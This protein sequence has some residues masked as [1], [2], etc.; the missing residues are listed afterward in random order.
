MT[1]VLTKPEDRLAT[2]PTARALIVRE[3]LQ[4][5]AEQRKLLLEYVKSQ[6][7]EDLDY[8]KIPGTD[9]PTLLKPGAEKLT[10]LFRT[11]ARFQIEKEI[12]DWD[13]GLF[14]YRF[15]CV[16]EDAEGNIVSEGI[17]SAN[18]REKRY[19]W[20]KAERTCPTCG[21]AAI[22]RS[23]FP[24][25]EEPEAQPG[26]Y[27]YGKIG[28][29]GANFPADDEEITNQVEGQIENPDIADCVN[30]LQKIS[31]KRALVDAV[32]G[33]SLC[34]DLF[35]QDLEDLA[36]TAATPATQPSA[37]AAKNGE[38]KNETKS[39]K[40]D[41]L[42]KLE[43]MIDDAKSR[44]EFKAA[45]FVVNQ[46][47]KSAGLTK[48]QR[49]GLAA[50][51]IAK[52]ATFDAT[53]PSELDAARAD[54]VAAI[55]ARAQTYA[56]MIFQFGKRVCAFDPDRDPIAPTLEDLKADELKS[57]TALIEANIVIPT[58]PFDEKGDAYEPDPIGDEGE[59]LALAN[60]KGKRWE[61]CLIWLNTT[62]RTNYQ[63]GT[64]FS[65]VTIDARKQ[66]VKS[67]EGIP[68]API[69]VA[70]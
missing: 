48:E 23:K 28:G 37:A 20:R 1:I 9:K 8:G 55:A 63:P 15:K 36:D 24:P 33:L 54:L 12:E 44:E 62:N 40:P 52:N 57:L 59:F 70:T 66:L 53:T 11:T 31:K 34:S 68:D 2:Q 64:K 32:L 21:K 67:L 13:M 19:R 61:E 14:Y 35:T 3:S 69:G 65:G 25:R 4:Q 47:L 39:P 22:K 56:K 51:A 46:Q 49:D 45:M 5:E 43:K 29:C 17:G 16:I 18:S 27:C 42:A 50:R 58:S 6:M 41:A 26:W 38:V 7:V 60:R 30:S 10:K